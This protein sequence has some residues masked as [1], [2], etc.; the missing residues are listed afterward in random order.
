MAPENT[1]MD[2]C[3]TPSRHVFWLMLLLLASPP[4][5]AVEAR[6]AWDRIVTLSVPVKGVI[7]RINGRP[8]ERVPAGSL[9]VQLD[10]RPFQARVAAQQARL[11]EEEAVLAEARRELARAEELYDRTVL[12][13]HE[14]QLKKNDVITAEARHAQAKA[15]LVRARLDLEYSSLRAPF[16]ARI[17]ARLAGVG[18]TVVADMRP[19]PVVRLAAADSLRVEARLAPAE[20]ARLHLGQRLPV[21]VGSARLEG[22]VVAIAAPEKESDDRYR[23]ALRIRVGDRPLLAGQ[24]AE[25][26]LP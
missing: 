10:Q 16:D 22:E 23:V 25:F 3:G 20:A 7:T 11:R 13:E 15:E 18:Q 19:T 6:L 9:L 5:Q 4:A 12:S 26:E 14:L 21:R 24:R 2:K 17:L 8:G 1:E